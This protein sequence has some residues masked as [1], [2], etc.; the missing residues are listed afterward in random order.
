MKRICSSTSARFAATL[1]AAGGMLILCGCN[2]A[3]QPL[4]INPLPRKK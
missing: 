2:Q 4:K 1:P 3:P